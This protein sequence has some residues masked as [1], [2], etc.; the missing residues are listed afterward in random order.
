MTGVGEGQREKR[1]RESEKEGAEGR[2]E[3]EGKVRESGV[4][5]KVKEERR[6]GTDGVRWWWRRRRK[7][8]DDSLGREKG[9]CKPTKKGN[10]DN[11]VKDNSE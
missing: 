1:V 9:A 11:D 4:E 2:E 3:R 6:E 7:E 5:L 8:C 10:E